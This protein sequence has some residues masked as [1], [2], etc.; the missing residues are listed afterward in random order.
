MMIFCSVESTVNGENMT[1]FR[2]GKYIS[3]ER[4]VAFDKAVKY[5]EVLPLMN[6][7]NVSPL[8]LPSIHNVDVKVELDEIVE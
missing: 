7:V 2:C 8:F 4:H 3:L 1:L 5:V 6:G